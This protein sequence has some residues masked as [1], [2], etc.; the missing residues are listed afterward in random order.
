MNLYFSANIGAVTLF[1]PH[2]GIYNRVVFYLDNRQFWRYAAMNQSS[3][4]LRM[5]LRYIRCELCAV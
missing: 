5:A 2:I 1:E 3:N 4:L